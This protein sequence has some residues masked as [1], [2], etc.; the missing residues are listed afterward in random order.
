MLIDG[1][2]T[3]R[4][5][6]FDISALEYLRGKHN[7]QNVA[8]AWAVARSFSITSEKIAASIKTFT[9]LPHRLETVAK[10]NGICFVNDSKA[11]NIEATSHAL[12]SF[13][14]IYWIAGGV[15]KELRLTP[16]LPHLDRVRRAYLIGE[17]AEKIGAELSE[18][19]VP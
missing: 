2:L 13:D 18:S 11:T 4:D 17:A 10:I 15:A 19:G 3:D 7:W 8:A 16:A 12:S 14:D 6:N 5:G 1:S 9:G